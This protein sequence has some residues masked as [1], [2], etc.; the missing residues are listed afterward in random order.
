MSGEVVFT[1]SGFGA[2]VDRFGGRGLSRPAARQLGRELDGL[3]ARAE[4]AAAT[5]QARAGLTGAALGHVGTLVT[6]GQ[7]LM[8]LAPEGGPYYQA[9]IAAYAIGATQAITRFQ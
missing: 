3:V 4:L 7:A 1:G 8:R 9:L 5:D 6:T 2:G